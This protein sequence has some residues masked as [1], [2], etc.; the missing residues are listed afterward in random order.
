MARAWTE[1]ERLK[2]NIRFSKPPLCPTCGETNPNKFYQSNGKITNAYCSDCHKERCK[3]RYHSKTMIER[4]AEKAVAYGL[5]VEEYLK[6]Y[7][8]QNGLCAICNSE[9]NTK[10]GLH[11]DHD[12]KTGKARGLLCHGCNIAIGNMKEDINILKAA[13]AYIERYN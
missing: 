11:V 10:R 8:D 9:P 12:H 6:L 3:Q 7:S 1:E 4:R 2:R 5:T 13:I